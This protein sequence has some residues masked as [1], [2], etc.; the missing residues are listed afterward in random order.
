MHSFD[1]QLNAQCYS[2]LNF[3]IFYQWDLNALDT[4]LC[5]CN[6]QVS[7]IWDK[8][9][10]F[11]SLLISVCVIRLMIRN[12]SKLRQWWNFTHSSKCLLEIGFYCRKKMMTYCGIVNDDITAGHI[13]M[14][15][16]LL[17]VLYKRALHSQ[18][19][20][21]TKK[22]VTFGILRFRCNTLKIK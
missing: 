18:R 10:K 11:L 12:S 6:I 1:L 15:N 9:R 16:V 20:K 13:A 2:I 14:E 3:C 22:K 5:C 4:Q 7:Q 17:Q 8:Q 21:A 19:D